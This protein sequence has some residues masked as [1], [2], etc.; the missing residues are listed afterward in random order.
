MGFQYILKNDPV[1]EQKYFRRLKHRMET[2]IQPNIWQEN[3]EI[4]MPQSCSTANQRVRFTYKNLCG[5][6]LYVSGWRQ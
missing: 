5:S 1:F 4:T 2:I 3:N 6:I